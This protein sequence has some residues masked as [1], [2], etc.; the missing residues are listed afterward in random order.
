MTARTRAYKKLRG[1]TLVRRFPRGKQP[2]Q[3]RR[4]MP[5]TAWRFNGRTRRGF[6]APAPHPRD[7]EAM[8]DFLCL[9]RFHL[10]GLSGKGRCRKST[11]LVNVFAYMHY[12]THSGGVC[13]ALFSEQRRHQ[14]AQ[15]QPEGV[16]SGVGHKGVE[17]RVAL[18]R[19]R[20][21]R[22]PEHHRLHDEHRQL[23]ERIE[24][25]HGK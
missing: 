19:L 8:F 22:Q 5:V 23:K 6:K 10:T 12:D 7:S 21:E 18:A 1:T 24:H 14:I 9:A 4:Q 3:L 11:L 13:Q 2:L 15:P 25:P 17:H 20:L 16:G